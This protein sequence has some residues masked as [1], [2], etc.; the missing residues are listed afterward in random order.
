MTENI[1]SDFVLN[2]G[3]GMQLHKLDQIQLAPLMSALIGLPPPVNNLAILPQGYMKVSREYARKSVHL[4]ALQ[5]LTQAKAI[6]RLHERG[7]FHKWLPKGKDL[8]L[9]QIAYYQNQMDHLLDMGW[10]SKALETSTLAIKVALK[11]L[12]F[13][14]NYYHIPLVVTTVLA[15][16]G[17]QF[18]QLVK[19]SQNVMAP[20]YMRRGYLTWCTIFLA[21]LGLL[22]GEMVFLQWAPFMT[23]ICLVVPF[24]VWCMTLAALPQNGGWIFEPLKHLRWI[25]GPAAVMIASIYCNCPLSLAYILCVGFYNR[26]GWL[27]P[28]PKFLAWLALVLLLGGFLWSQKG[29][30][31]LMTTNY[32]VVLQAISML[33]VIV[34]PCVLNENHKWKVWVINGGILFV[35]AIGIFLKEMG[36]PVPLYLFAANWAYL[37]Y[38]FASVPCSSRTTPQSRLELIRFNLLTLHV[39]LSDSYVSLFAQGLIIEYQMGLEVHEKFKE[40]DEDVKIL[41]SSKHLQM[42][43][44]FAVS[45]L[46]YFYASLFGTGHWV[47]GFTYLAN[48]A[49]LFLPD[50]SSGLVPLLVLIHL[51]I[52]SIV[53]MA[54]VVALSSF[55]RQQIRTIFSSLMLICNA[56]VLFFVV[57]VPHNAYWP[58]AH[59]SVV[60]ALLAQLTVI[61]ILACES[62]VT[63]FF[64]RLNMNRCSDW[65]QEADEFE[66]SYPR[67]PQLLSN[68]LIKVL[69]NYNV[70]QIYGLYI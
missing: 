50:S 35:A 6:I 41:T 34:R 32:R 66:S 60:H 38:A 68:C 20:H 61:L 2:N 11:S 22:L 62:I 46:L 14:H 26:R 36:K 18:Y 65:R 44:R 21:S 56:V 33:V 51:L 27:H 17:W 15:L 19:L 8:D 23:V 3:V 1:T 49:R 45:I 70:K 16:L 47:G 31:I 64:R 29:M 12:K 10:R 59:P 39:L 5:L 53:I 24:G 28:S 13:Y 4:N 63:I 37:I 48:S 9:Q 25:V 57:F 40:A 67:L 52:P 58:M 43:Y 7:V 69:R 55:G 54:S 30:Q 42:C